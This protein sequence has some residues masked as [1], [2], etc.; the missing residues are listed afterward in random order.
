MS[1]AT[2][3]IRSVQ[4]Q[5]VSGLYKIVEGWKDVQLS[6]LD[7]GVQALALVPKDIESQLQET[8]KLCEKKDVIFAKFNELLKKLGHEEKI[9]NE[10]DQAAWEA[11]QA[12]LSSWLDSESSYRLEVEKQKEAEEGAAFARSEYEKWFSTVK[13]TKERLASMEATYP[14]EKQSIAD[15]RALL[16][17]ILRLLGIMEDQP[18][19]DASKAAGGYKAKDASVL[20]SLKAKVAE[21]KLQA[22][23]GGAIPE[24]FTDGFACL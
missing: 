5:S 6:N 22:T 24:S 18:L 15:E 20:K 8:G 14:E 7:S 10:T 4:L 1:L 12:A 23:K 9:R 19:D 21:L 17:E 3:L 2:Q 11:K 13:K 16:K